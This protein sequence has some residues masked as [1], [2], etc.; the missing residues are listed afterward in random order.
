MEISSHPILAVKY[1]PGY[2]VNT[3]TGR[4]FLLSKE[5]TFAITDEIWK[6]LDEWLAKHGPE[7]KKLF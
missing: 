6:D 4:V 5:I 3:T 7:R 2:I 1:L